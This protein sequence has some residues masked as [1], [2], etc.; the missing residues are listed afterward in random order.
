MRET[1]ARRLHQEKSSLNSI[2]D[3]HMRE[4]HQITSISETLK[5]RGIDVTVFQAEAHVQDQ[6]L[7]LCTHYS[8]MRNAV[9]VSHNQ[10]LKQRTAVDPKAQ[11]WKID[12]A[13]KRKLSDA[14]EF[15]SLST[16]NASEQHAA[17]S[18][19]QFRRF[20]KG[21]PARDQRV[22]MTVLHLHRLQ[23]LAENQWQISEHTVCDFHALEVSQT[24]QHRV[25]CEILHSYIRQRQNADGVHAAGTADLEPRDLSAFRRHVHRV[26]QQ[27]G[28]RS[29]EVNRSEIG[30]VNF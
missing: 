29:V 10:S 20:L 21:L 2:R 12:M 25:Q 30:S 22:E 23:L 15:H 3:Q 18:A 6:A 7:E 1:E 8:E 9:A 13:H 28:I 17:E 14:A 5:I 11:I 16:V 27:I 4:I 24:R 19:H 26:H